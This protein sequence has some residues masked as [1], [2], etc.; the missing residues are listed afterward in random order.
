MTLIITDRLNRTLSLADDKSEYSKPRDPTNRPKL[1]SDLCIPRDEQKALELGL[2]KE[3]CKKL[4][5]MSMEEFNVNIKVIFGS[6][7]CLIIQEFT[8]KRRF[9]ED[10]L[11]IL[12]DMRYVIKKYFLS[13]FCC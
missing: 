5:P 11:S 12:R 6:L 13:L 10:K 3:E 1:Y 8:Q 4:V 2:T 7:Q 9:D